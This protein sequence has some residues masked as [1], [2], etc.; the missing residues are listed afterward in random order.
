MT[1]TKKQVAALNAAFTKGG[2]WY[3]R[4]GGLAGGAYR[5]MCFRLAD[6]G[7]VS[8]N[9]PYPITQAGLNVLRDER[10]KRWADHGSMAT[11]LDLEAVEKAL[12]EFPD[13]VAA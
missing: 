1:L 10:A 5:R 4:K 12:A 9:P 6:L 3:G 11:L 2:A 13:T 8:E 7:L